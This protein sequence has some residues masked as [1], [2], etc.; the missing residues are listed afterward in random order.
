M[1]SNFIKF[2]SVMINTA[3]ISRIDIQL[4]KYS[5]HFLDDKIS[6]IWL[7]GGGVLNS[8]K[9]KILDICKEKDPQDYKMLTDWINKID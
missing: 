5:I 7:F 9:D 4:N 6:G 1:Y 3:K 2:S 8:N